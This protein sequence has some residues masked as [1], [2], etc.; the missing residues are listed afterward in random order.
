[1]L[2]TRSG[3]RTAIPRAS[4][5]PRLCPTICTREPRGSRSTRAATRAGRRRS[6]CS[7]RWR[8]CGS[9]R[10]GSPGCAAPGT[11]ARGCRRRRG[12]PG[13]RSTGSPRRA[14]PRAA[15]GVARRVRRCAG[16]AERVAADLDDRAAL[17]QHRC[18]PAGGRS[19]SGSRKSAER[20]R[21]TCG[22]RYVPPTDGIRGRIGG[23]VPD[24]WPTALTWRHVSAH[25]RPTPAAVA[26]SE[27]L[28][29]PVGRGIELCYQTFGDPDD[30]PLLLVMGLGGPMTWWDPELCEDAGP[31]R[32][33]RRPLRQ[34]RHRPLHDPGGP[35]LAQ[36]AG[37]RLRGHPGARAVRA[38]RTWPTT[39]SGCSTTSGST[40]AHVVGVSMGGMIVQTMA[41][42]HPEPGPVADQHHVDDRQAH[43]RLAAPVAAA[44][45]ARRPQARARGVRPASTDVLGS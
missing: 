30:D 15:Y 21:T 23:V 13:T 36:H 38:S 29:A 25:D 7:R 4:M 16:G 27:E 32:L 42:S 28:F 3:R 12:S 5:P 35:G 18:R 39:P 6:A 40:S 19:P 22:A 33:L 20:R 17:A 44:R 34:P 2:E 10:C 41:I 24:S 9:G 26:V 1:M 43:R 8:G 37:P 45:A 14:P 31:R 11:S